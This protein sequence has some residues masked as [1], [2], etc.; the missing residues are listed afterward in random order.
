[1]IFFENS[2][3]MPKN[4]KGGPFGIFNIHSAEKYRKIEGGPFGEKFC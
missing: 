3:T 2:L 1:M 4:W